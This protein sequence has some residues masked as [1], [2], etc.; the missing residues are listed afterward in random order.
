MWDAHGFPS[1]PARG[2]GSEFRARFGTAF[3]GVTAGVYV[4]GG[5]VSLGLDFNRY[6]GIEWRSL[7]GGTLSIDLPTLEPRV[8]LRSDSAGNGLPTLGIGTALTGIRFVR[9][10][11]VVDLRLPRVDLW[12]GPLDDRAHPTFS[13]GGGLSVGVIL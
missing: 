9:C 4:P 10:P 7:A 5:Q 12:V 2:T 1:G 8:L 11:F 3:V 13:L 6:S